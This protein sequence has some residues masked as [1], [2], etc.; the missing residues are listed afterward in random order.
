MKKVAEWHEVGN[1]RAA[2]SAPKADASWILVAF[3]IELFRPIDSIQYLVCAGLKDSRG[4]DQTSRRRLVILRRQQV[5]PWFPVLVVV[6]N[7]DY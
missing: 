2:K 5:R 7:F 6:G 1:A 4:P 3:T